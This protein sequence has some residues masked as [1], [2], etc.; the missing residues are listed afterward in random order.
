[1]NGCNVKQNKIDI[2]VYVLSIKHLDKH[3]FFY[4]YFSIIIM[5]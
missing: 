5:S 1:M 2:S 4:Y 3:V